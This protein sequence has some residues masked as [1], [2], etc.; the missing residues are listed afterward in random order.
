MLTERTKN[1]NEK[2]DFHRMRRASLR[3]G[4]LSSSRMNIVNHTPAK[5]LSKKMKV[6]NNKRKG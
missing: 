1:A 6:A 3:V 4:T 5:Q 2:R